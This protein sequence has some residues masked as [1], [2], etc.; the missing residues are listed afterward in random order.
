MNVA[1]LLCGPTPDRGGAIEMH[2]V[3]AG[4]SRGLVRRIWPDFDRA[5]FEATRR[6]FRE[7]SEHCFTMEERRARSL[8]GVPEDALVGAGVAGTTEGEEDDD[9][10]GDE[11]LGEN[12]MIE[13]LGE[14]RDLQT[15]MEPELAAEVEL[16]GGE[17]RR[18]FKRRVRF[19]MGDWELDRGETTWRRIAPSP[20]LRDT[21][22]AGAGEE[23]ADEQ[24]GKKGATKEDKGHHSAAGSPKRTRT[25]HEDGGGGGKCRGWSCCTDTPT[26]QGPRTEAAVLVRPEEDPAA[27]ARSPRGES[28]RKKAHSSLPTRPMCRVKALAQKTPRTLAP[29]PAS[30]L[31]PTPASK[32]LAPD[33][34]EDAR[35]DAR[36]EGARPDDPRPDARLDPRPDASLEGAR[37][38]NTEDA[39]PDVCLEGAHPDDP[40]PD[41][42]S[43][44][45]RPDDPRP[46]AR[47][48][49]P[50]PD[51][52]EEGDTWA[53]KD[54]QM[55][56]QELRN[57]VDGFARLRRW[58][59]GGLGG[60]RQEAHRGK[61]AVPGEKEG[62]RP[63]LVKSF[64][65]DARQWDKPVDLETK[66]IGPRSLKGS[67]AE[68]WWGWWQGM[69]P[70][71]REDD[72]ELGLSRPENLTEREWED[73]AKTH[74]RNGCLAR[75]AAANDDTLQDEWMRAVRDVTWVLGE[76]VKGVPALVK[77]LAAEAAN[78]E[79]EEKV[80]KKQVNR[81]SGEEGGEGG[82]GDAFG[83]EKEGRWRW[84]GEG[85]KKTQAHIE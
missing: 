78:L 68:I 9:E 71:G 8:G 54:R 7:F 50:R 46:D 66:E 29:M 28:R 83:W 79:Q 61:L 63:S 3:H 80:R 76:A 38:D 72:V 77:H 60:L 67:F 70:E 26:P 30:T 22:R 73:V 33:N 81:G 32:A 45:P 58:G 64:M 25:A 15:A 37:P 21:S 56:Q 75:S 42:R 23:E 39:R 17:E 74:G 27:E 43:D 44:D 84:R 5:G 14:G 51:E 12:E 19:L 35:P 62:G 16:M 55:W 65:H 41:T 1:I 40:R 11:E 20:R 49:D 18:R 6:S 34:A 59:W 53:W 82:E 36:L 2:S 52:D 10:E 48:D 24:G 47:P 13:G 57:A 85:I 4:T 31:A 69:Q